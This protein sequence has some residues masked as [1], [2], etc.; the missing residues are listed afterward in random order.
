MV[1]RGM[2]YRGGDLE[3][4]RSFEDFFA[5]EYPSLVK[6]LYLLTGSQPEAEDVVQEAMAR[7]FSSWPR[8]GRMDSPWGYVYV[9]AANEWKR[10]QRRHRLLPIAIPSSTATDPETV[11]EVMDLLARMPVG[12]RECVILVDW[13]GLS[14]GEAASILGI[15]SSTV[16]GRLQRSREALRKQRTEEE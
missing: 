16:R 6:A 10:R 9:S 5:L 8:V 15:R 4:E 13:L 3:S 12:W 1:A 2:S 11:S 7:V 14:S